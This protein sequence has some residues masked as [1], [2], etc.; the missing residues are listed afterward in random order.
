MVV[1]LFDSV[2]EKENSKMVHVPKKKKV[3]V[4]EDS[5]KVAHLQQ[6]LLLFIP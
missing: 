3:Y 2:M 1:C 6:T 4:L 5:Q